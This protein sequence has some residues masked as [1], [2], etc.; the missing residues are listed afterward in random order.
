MLYIYTYT[1][2]YTPPCAAGD[3]RLLLGGML[4][5]L[6]PPGMDGAKVADKGRRNADIDGSAT[7]SPAP[8]SQQAGI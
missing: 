7:R 5:G 8:S 2:V 4:D 6:L 3:V 1:Y